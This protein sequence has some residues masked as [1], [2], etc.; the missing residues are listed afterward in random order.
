[1]GAQ[2]GLSTASPRPAPEAGISRLS[3]RATPAPGRGKLEGQKRRGVAGWALTSRPQ[4][5]SPRRCVWKIENANPQSA[6]LSRQTPGSWEMRLFLM[7]DKDVTA[8]PS[9]E[10]GNQNSSRTTPPAPPEAGQRDCPRHGHRCPAAT[11]LCRARA[12]ITVCGSGADTLASS[13][14][15]DKAVGLGSGSKGGRVEPAG[16]PCGKQPIDLAHSGSPSRWWPWA[17]PGPEDAPEEAC[18]LT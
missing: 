12:S 10:G 17:A 14:N 1:M 2:R 11:G 16:W 6:S 3:P 8:K 9:G 15:S 13:D 7:P 4:H 18:V 5:A